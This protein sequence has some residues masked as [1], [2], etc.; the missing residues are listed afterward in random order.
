MV[1]LSERVHMKPPNVNFNLYTPTLYFILH[2]CKFLN[3]IEHSDHTRF[4]VIMK[5]EGVKTDI[6]GWIR[7]EGPI[8]FIKIIFLKFSLAGED[9]ETAIVEDS[10]DRHFR[11]QYEEWQESVSD[12]EVHSAPQSERSDETNF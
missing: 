5:G 11:E 1:L 10:Q 12:G 3:T 9:G 2:K 6:I 4:S 7:V 8:Q